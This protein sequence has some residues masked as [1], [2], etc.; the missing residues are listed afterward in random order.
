MKNGTKKAKTPLSSNCSRTDRKRFP[1][2]L[3]TYAIVAIWL[4]LVAKAT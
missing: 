2:T 4:G 3:S 1:F